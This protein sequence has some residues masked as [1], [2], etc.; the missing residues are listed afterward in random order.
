[1]DAE[2][3]D[4]AEGAV[5]L[6]ASGQRLSVEC[7]ASPVAASCELPC[8]SDSAC[9]ELGTSYACDQG[10]CRA[11][12]LDCEVGQFEATDLV[13]LGDNFLADSGEIRT[14]LEELAREAGLLDGD[15]RYRDYSSALV[16][17]FGGDADLTVQYAAA[18]GEGAV[19]VAVL[20]LGGPDALLPCPAPPAADCPSLAAAQAGAEDLLATLHDDGVTDA[21]V[22]FY[23][24]PEDEALRANFDV[25][26]PLIRSACDGAPLACHFLDLRPV[27]DGNE[28]EY[29][30]PGGVL[31]TQAGAEA[32][33]RAIWSVMQR[34]CVA[35]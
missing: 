25:L 23:P 5:C 28:A 9:E 17:P 2:C 16:T 14:S 13:L 3:S 26:R 7:A 31:P 19:R 33:A 21:V 20:D 11:L 12:A 27:F 1:M 32:T 4:L 29:L 10:F 35:Q 6:P 24:N 30:E 8:A 18:L 15:E 34:S 22:F